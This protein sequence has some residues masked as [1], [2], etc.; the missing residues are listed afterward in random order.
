MPIQLVNQGQIKRCQPRYPFAREFHVTQTENHWTN[1]NT[2]LA[3]IKEVL[4][5]YVRKVRQKL[6]LPEDQQ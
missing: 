2:S 4:V 5:S 3:I 6:S 1:A